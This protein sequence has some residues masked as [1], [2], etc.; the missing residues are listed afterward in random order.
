MTRPSAHRRGYTRRWRAI[1]RDA[2]EVHV[3]LNGWTCPGYGIPGHYSA[4]LTG[5]HELPVSRGGLTTRTNTQILCR[6]C[7]SRKRDRPPIRVQM[8]LDLAP[9]GGGSGPAFGTIA[10]GP[11]LASRTPTKDSEPEVRTSEPDR[12]S[13]AVG[14][15]RTPA[16]RF[17]S[18][19]R[20]PH[21]SEVTR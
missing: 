6:A 12:P 10:R 13:A 16:L 11:D 15:G 20:P 14:Q 2:L 18:S 5:D 19:Y 7:N 9:S 17:P 3:R 4:D 1:V 8:T 21:P